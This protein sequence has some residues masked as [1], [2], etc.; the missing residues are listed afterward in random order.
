MNSPQ[1][2]RGPNHDPQTP[3]DTL[4]NFKMRKKRQVRPT[5]T[6]LGPDDTIG[7]GDSSIH[8]D[9]TSPNSHS[10]IG[11]HTVFTQLED[12]VSWQKMTHAGGEVPRLVC[13][14]GDIAED[15]SMPVYRH[16]SD[17]SLPL[18]QF[19]PLVRHLRDCAEEFVGHP[20]NHV[21]IQL[22]RSG[23]DF[24]SEHS[25]KT[26]DIVR[27]SKIINVSFGA[28]RTMR[29]RTK[30]SAL[31]SDNDLRQTQRI[32]MPHNSIFVLG[33]NTNMRWLHGITADKR[34][35]QER[36]TAEKAFNGK[37]ISLTFRHIGTFLDARGER[38]WGQGATAKTVDEARPTINGDEEATQELINAFGME[39]HEADFDWEE[40]Y[41]GGFDVLHFRL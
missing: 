23:T 12:E 37:R 4:G 39:N 3:D 16:P 2:L 40:T 27:G 17:Q 26:L 32:P 7:E 18:M 28:Q 38:I 19:S 20:L 41:G 9:F 5:S 13:M 21:L 8:Y 31:T 11:I 36:S 22:Y 6:T 30:R 15:G 10:E 29:L 24:I 33:Q 35:E 1:A 14:Q 34:P 25:D